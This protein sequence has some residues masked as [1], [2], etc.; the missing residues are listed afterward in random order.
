MGNL[1]FLGNIIALETTGTNFQGNGGPSQLGLYL[2]QIGLPGTP[3]MVLCMAD[4]VTR[5]RVFSANI[6][7]P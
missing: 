4:L 5:Y 7:G 3:G 2:N 1:Y 6:A